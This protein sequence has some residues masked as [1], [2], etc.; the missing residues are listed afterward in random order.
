MTHPSAANAADRHLM[1]RLATGD[2][3]ALE[4]ILERHWGSLLDYAARWLDTPDVAQDLVQEAFIRLWD[5]RARWDG[6]SGARPILFRMVRNLA[7]DHRR[8]AAANERRLKSLPAAPP[9]SPIADGLEET[10][11]I[12]AVYQALERLNPREREIVVLSRIQGLTRAEV[13][14]VTGLAPGT[15]SNLLS[16][17]MTRL[18]RAVERL[19]ADD[20]RPSI[21]PIRHRLRK[22]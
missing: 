5:R 4:D 21:Q 2:E 16:L 8:Q 6:Q 9:V 1:A 20:E 17:G 10:E 14:A 22:V 7:I 19:I 12:D 15:V 11:L 13:A 18:W 3:A